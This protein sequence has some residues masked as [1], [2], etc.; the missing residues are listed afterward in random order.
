MI[1]VNAGEAAGLLK[2]LSNPTR[3]LVMCALVTREYTA[4]E[5]ESLVGVGQ[6]A[7]SQH[8]A[9][10]RS[11]NLVATRRGGQRIFYSLADD[12]VRRIITTLHDIYCAEL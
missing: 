4:G 2:V 5:L 3:L 11:E 7:L 10:L 1:Q 6:S 12:R 8:L 9:K